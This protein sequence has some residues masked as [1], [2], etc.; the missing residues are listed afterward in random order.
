MFRTFRE[1]VAK[2]G[3]ESITRTESQPMTED[4]Q[5]AGSAAAA[6]KAMGKVIQIDRGLVQKHLSEAVRSTMEETVNAMLEAEATSCAEPD[7][8]STVPGSVRHTAGLFCCG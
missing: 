1:E 3:G 6:D 7:V 8:T 2:G 4:N 5:A